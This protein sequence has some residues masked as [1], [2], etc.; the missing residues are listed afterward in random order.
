[1]CNVLEVANAAEIIVNGYAFVK[2]GK[3]IKVLNLNHTDRA[4]VLSVEGEV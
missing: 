1:M 2:M 4:A 3:N